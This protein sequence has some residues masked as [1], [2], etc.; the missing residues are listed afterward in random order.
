MYEA[1]CV[2]APDGTT[3]L[4]IFF[5]GFEDHEDAQLFLRMLMAPYVSPHYSNESESVH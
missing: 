3:R 5:D 2:R 4:A 1:Y